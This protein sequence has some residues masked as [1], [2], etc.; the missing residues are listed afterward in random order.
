MQTGLPSP[1]HG[2]IN[3][4]RAGAYR[5]SQL[6]RLNV[7]SCLFHEDSSQRT[8]Y[9]VDFKRILSGLNKVGGK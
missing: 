2:I 4:S 1:K 8:S 9:F 5:D 7:W 6:I 3:P